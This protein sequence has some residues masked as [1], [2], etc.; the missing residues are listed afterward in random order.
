VHE[1]V[2]HALELLELEND[3]VPVELPW[4]DVVRLGPAGVVALSRGFLA[5]SSGTVYF[6]S[7]LKSAVNRIVKR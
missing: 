3:S 2:L 7:D 4:I 5:E 6:S 1:A